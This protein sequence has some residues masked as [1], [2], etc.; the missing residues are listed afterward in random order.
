MLLRQHHALTDTLIT[1]I[2]PSRGGDLAAA[3]S[4]LDRANGLLLYGGA[5][6]TF[7]LLAAAG[8]IARRTEAYAPASTSAARRIGRTFAAVGIALAL[9]ASLWHATQLWASLEDYRAIAGQGTSA[10]SN[11]ATARDAQ[12]LRR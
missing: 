10:N 1:L 4:A 12:A 6:L 5:L 2:D 9:V 7:I 11:T 3:A 8:A